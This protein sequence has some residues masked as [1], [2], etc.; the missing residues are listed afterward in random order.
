M[1]S[2]AAVVAQE[3]AVDREPPGPR[4][5]GVDLTVAA[6][7]RLAVVG[8][9][10]V[11]KTTLLATLALMIAPAAGRLFLFGRE[12]AR[13]TGAERAAVR[14]R[15]G[16]AVGDGPWLDDASVTDNLALPLRVHGEDERAVGAVVGEFLDWLGLGDRREAPVA[17]LSTGERRLLD[18]AR[19]AVV[20]PDLLLLDEPLAGLDG[21]TAGRVAQLVG[22]LAGLGAAVVVATAEAD[23]ARRLGC[24]A[25]TLTEGG[26]KMGAAP[27]RAAS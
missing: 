10:G 4:C 9:N 5:R 20:R 27:L 19:A 14:R 2:D 6:G 12:P 16:A 1:P 11:G 8:A 7:E 18:V 25:V 24:E 21:R 22:E 23:T 17:A 3:L 13:L 15:I 26:L